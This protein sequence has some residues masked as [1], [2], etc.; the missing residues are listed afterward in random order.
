M[1]TRNMN[2]I[3]LALGGILIVAPFWVNPLIGNCEQRTM[4]RAA[5][6][7][8]CIAVLIRLDRIKEGK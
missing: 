2:R 4:I 1:M 7:V 5:V 8:L 6:T 3:L